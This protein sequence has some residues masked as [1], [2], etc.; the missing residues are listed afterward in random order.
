[1]ST[2]NTVFTEDLVLDDDEF[3]LASRRMN[4]LSQKIRGLRKDLDEMLDLL[5]DG[6]NT[7]AG[8]KLIKSCKDN[9]CAPIDAQELVI[10][11]ICQTLAQ[12]K[13]KYETVFSEYTSLKSA[14]EQSK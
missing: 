3:E 13:N 14:I 5:E 12:A 11:H 6:F 9:L 10:E 2:P 8:K 1:M 7:P 4:D